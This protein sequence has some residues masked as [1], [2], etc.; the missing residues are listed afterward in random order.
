[1]AMKSFNSTI[2][3]PGMFSLNTFISRDTRLGAGRS[4][5]RTHTGIR[6]EMNRKPDVERY[7]KGQ[8]ES[9]QQL[10]T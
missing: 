6:G 9:E 10:R 2:V 7:G 5:V 8:T 4:R 3:N 1:M